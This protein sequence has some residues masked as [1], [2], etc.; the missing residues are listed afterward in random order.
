MSARWTNLPT[1]RGVT[2]PR[3]ELR[4]PT[5]VGTDATHDLMIGF[6]SKTFYSNL[7]VTCS[8]KHTNT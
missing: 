4:R 6:D 2:R 1:Q 8:F 7:A 3:E 5:G